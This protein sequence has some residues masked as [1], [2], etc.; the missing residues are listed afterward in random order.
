MCV[1]SLSPPFAQKNTHTNNIDSSIVCKVKRRRARR[2]EH[3]N[4]IGL[5][6]FC[7]AM[8]RKVAY[9][10]CCDVIC[11][12]FFAS[13]FLLNFIIKSGS[14]IYSFLSPSKPTGDYNREKHERLP[15]FFLLKPF[16]LHKSVCSF[17][18]AHRFWCDESCVVQNQ[19]KTE[20]RCLQVL[21][22]FYSHFNTSF[23]TAL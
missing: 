19:T 12:V 10:I 6:F 21:L 4:N 17:C 2:G 5:N 8:F 15:V 23:F 1:P 20:T 13:F 16:C 22:L 3:T 18:K 7:L 9:L 14:I 11:F